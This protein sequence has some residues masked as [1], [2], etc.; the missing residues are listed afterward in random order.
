V[1]LRQLAEADL[2]A[3][4]EDGAT[5]FG[6]PITVTSPAEMS[7]LLTGFSDDISQIID[8]DTGQIVSGRLASIA[9]RI[10][11]LTAAGFEL[12]QGIADAAQKPWLV[13]FDDINGNSFTF[14][15]MQSNPDRA[16]GIVTCILEL[17]RP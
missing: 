17:Y 12:P 7:A 4:L 3:V 16:L 1:S 15:V 11:S 13:T 9:L 8:P 2:G 5:G 6:W 10:S 14:K